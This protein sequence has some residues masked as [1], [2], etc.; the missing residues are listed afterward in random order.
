MPSHRKAFFDFG[1]HLK[2]EGV[3]MLSRNSVSLRGKNILGLEYFS[4]EEIEL[5]LDTAK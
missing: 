2:C 4:P 5:V 1:F 3:T